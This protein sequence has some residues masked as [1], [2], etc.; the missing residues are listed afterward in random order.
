MTKLYLQ[1]IPVNIVFKPK[2]N[3]N[4]YFRFKK[5][6]Y[7][8]INLAKNQ[9]EKQVIDYIKKNPSKFLEKYQKY[10]ITNETKI[11]SMYI[12]G[13]KYQIVTDESKGVSID[14]NSKLLYKPKDD[15]SNE[16]FDNILL[17]MFHSELLKLIHKYSRNPY[18]DIDHVKYNVKKMSSR[19]G[20]CSKSK[21]RISLNVIL[22]HYDKKYLEYVFLHEIT[23]LV[24]ANHAA[25][26][27][28]LLGKLCKDHRVL[29]KQLNKI[30][31]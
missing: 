31:L 5:E 26:F 17:D 28:E 1:N 25:E 19:F 7:I 20:S 14:E 24:H 23:H 21:R 9:S 16:V 10:C 15:C 2:N 3:K 18:V 30:I 22:V 6:G 12:W 8:Q 29:R 27:Y 11:D 4:T 13:I